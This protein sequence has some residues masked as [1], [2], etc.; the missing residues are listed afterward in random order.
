MQKSTDKNLYLYR[1]IEVIR[2]RNTKPFYRVQ[3]DRQTAG[4]IRT[5]RRLA[6]TIAPG[7]NLTALFLNHSEY[8]HKTVACLWNIAEEVAAFFVHSHG[9]FCERMQ[10]VLVF[11]ALCPQQR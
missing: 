9:D 8:D 3:T 1:P 5:N 10:F 11:S 6:V 7:K 2:D 4:R